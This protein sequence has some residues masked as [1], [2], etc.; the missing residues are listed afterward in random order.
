M[1]NRIL[2]KLI[3]L[4]F[5]IVLF[6]SCQSRIA[7]G[8]Q[9]LAADTQG[10]KDLNSINAEL[11]TTGKI[12]RES[13]RKL[14]GL[15]QKYPASNSVIR[16]YKSALVLRKDIVAFEEYS[17]L[18]PSAEQSAEDKISLATLYV[19]NGKHQ[20]A[21][22]LL[23]PM[24]EQLSEDV[25]VRELLGI[26]Y[27][28]LGNMVEAGKAYDSVWD[29]VIANKMTEA[30]ATR[31]IIFYKSG[32][33][34]KAIATLNRALELDPNHISSNY[35]LS[36]IYNQQGDAE[37]AESYRKRTDE[38]QNQLKAATYNK[39]KNVR[40]TYDLQDAWKEKR[41]SDVIKFANKML[42]TT[43]ERNQKLVLYKYLYES[44]K[45]LG[46]KSE[47]QSALDQTQKLKA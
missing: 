14:K 20:K 26:S 41:Y 44:Y 38:L 32:E 37:K 13:Y 10:L 3:L 22:D 34:S 33:L 1:R 46:M 7:D 9:R 19:L 30:I 24:S 6:G 12:S 2:S 5:G 28:N 42:L 11:K 31:G 4:I 43:T 35:T 27:Y 16:T 29:Q 36:R 23:V 39:S 21:L 47:A 17:S 25:M 40:L 18:V 15:F 8:D 45:A